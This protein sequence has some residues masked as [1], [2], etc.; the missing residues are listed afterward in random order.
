MNAEQ[1]KISDFTFTKLYQCPACNKDLAISY[2]KTTGLYNLWCSR[3]ACTNE[4]T[5]QGGEGSTEKQAF[6]RLQ[7]NY[8]EE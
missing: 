5:N 6:Q 2:N 8:I 4:S 3:G 7:H 1:Y